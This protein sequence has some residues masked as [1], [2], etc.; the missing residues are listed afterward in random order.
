MIWNADSRNVIPVH[1]DQRVQQVY[2][3][4]W[5]I[6]KEG[7]AELFLARLTTFGNNEGIQACP[8][9]KRPVRCRD[10]KNVQAWVWKALHLSKALHHSLPT[11]TGLRWLPSEGATP[12][13]TWSGRRISGSGSYTFVSIGAC[14]SSE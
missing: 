1:L 10:G 9:S 14:V 4:A 7:L 13:W 11:V 8:H 5:R 6:V 12:E 2:N 3:P